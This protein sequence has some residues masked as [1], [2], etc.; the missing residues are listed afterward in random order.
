MLVLYVRNT[1]YVRV[2]DRLSMIYYCII[3]TLYN[4]IEGGIRMSIKFNVINKQFFSTGYNFCILKYNWKNCIEYKFDF[5]STYSKDHIKKKH[6]SK[7]FIR[8]ILETPL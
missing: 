6:V 2:S 8:R 1:I 3:I 4:I 5:S 7:G